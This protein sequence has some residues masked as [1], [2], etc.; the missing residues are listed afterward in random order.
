MFFLIGFL[1]VLIDQII[2]II[3]TANIPYGEAIGNWIRLTNISN[4]GMAY[5]MRKR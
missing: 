2:K 5:S 3:I 4:T 1:I